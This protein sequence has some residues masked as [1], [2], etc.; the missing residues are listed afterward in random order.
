[1]N[2]DFFLLKYKAPSMISYKYN[3]EQC[4]SMIVKEERKT[5]TVV[6]PDGRD[7]RT[8]TLKVGCVPHSVSWLL[9]WCFKWEGWYLGVCND[10]YHF[11][12]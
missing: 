2:L 12:D 11:S 4:F 3:L 8:F 5:I 10:V 6:F 7:G 9:L 1:V